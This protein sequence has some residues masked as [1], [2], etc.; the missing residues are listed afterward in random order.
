MVKM[1]QRSL[2]HNKRRFHKF[3]DTSAESQEDEFNFNVMLGCIDL[4]PIEFIFASGLHFLQF[5]QPAF[6]IN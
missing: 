4:R 1:A 2:L 5:L 6:M 3:K